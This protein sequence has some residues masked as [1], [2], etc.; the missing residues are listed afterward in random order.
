MGS[1]VRDVRV[2]EAAAVSVGVEVGAAVEAASVAAE[3]ICST[4]LVERAAVEPKTGEG[5][6]SGPVNR[7]GVRPVKARH[8]TWLS[9]GLVIIVV[10]TVVG[11]TV[12]ESVGETVGETAAG[13]ES[14]GGRPG[15]SINVLKPTSARPLP[16]GSE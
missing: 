8:P 3:V 15:H 4:T 10:A 6:P 16:R 5:T 2:E 9:T 11:E 12:G 14:T 1:D 7:E 13:A